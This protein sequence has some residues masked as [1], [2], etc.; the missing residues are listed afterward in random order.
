MNLFT[1]KTANYNSYKEDSI[2]LVS[3]FLASY[4]V[5]CIGMNWLR[6]ERRG[7]VKSN[8]NTSNFFLLQKRGSINIVITIWWC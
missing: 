3:S 1:P 6:E 5:A 2:I 8:T 7:S 4:L